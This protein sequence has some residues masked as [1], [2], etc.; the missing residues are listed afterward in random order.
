[1]AYVSNKPKA[2]LELTVHTSQFAKQLVKYV[3]AL[4]S[5]VATSNL[6]KL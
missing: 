4:R 3:H 6:F 2:E 5:E 1:M